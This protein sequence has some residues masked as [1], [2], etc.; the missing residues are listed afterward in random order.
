MTVKGILNS[1]I[2]YTNK[3]FILIKILRNQSF[4]KTFTVLWLDYWICIT[5]LSRNWDLFL[6]DNCLTLGCRRLMKIDSCFPNP[7][8]LK[9]SFLHHI[10]CMIILNNSRLIAERFK[11]C[12]QSKKN[13][14]TFLSILFLMG[15]SKDWKIDSWVKNN[16][17]NL[18][19]I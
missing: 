2:C 19:A 13:C 18:M 7:K 10:N 8:L 14:R 4:C 1:Q 11:N 16:L 17:V 6:L 5:Y 15:F 9:G 3:A 12:H